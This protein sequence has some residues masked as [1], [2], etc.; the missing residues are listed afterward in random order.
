MRILAAVLA[1]LIVLIQFPLW[2]GKGGWLRVWDLDRQLQ[3][4]KDRNVKAQTRNAELDAE[5]GDLKQGLEAVEERAR[6]DLGMIKQDEVFFQIVDPQPKAGSTT[7]KEP[8]ADTRS[9]R[10]NKR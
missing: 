7:T 10:E 9:P 8:D 2:L 6:Y 1:G 3:S 5:V 4:R